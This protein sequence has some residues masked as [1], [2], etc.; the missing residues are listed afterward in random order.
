MRAW[1]QAYLAH[2]AAI[3]KQ[4]LARNVAGVIGGKEG[5]GLSDV[6]R[7]SRASQ[8]DLRDHLGKNVGVVHHPA[9]HRRVDQAGMNAVD[10]DAGWANLGGHV[11]REGFDGQLA[12]RIMRASGKDLSRLDGT[13]VHDGALA[14]LR[15]QPPAEDLRGHP[16]A[17]QVH[18]DHVLPLLVRQ[19]QERD[20]G[21]DAGVVDQDVDGTELLPRLCEQAFEIFAFGDIARDGERAAPKPTYVIG[22]LFRPRIELQVV[23]DDVRAFRGEGLR[24][25]A[26]DALPRSR[27]NGDPA[28]E[29]HLPH[30]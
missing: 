8:R 18:V 5:D 3:D 15:N 26:A 1:F 21:L 24:D 29:P 28:F 25:A 12:G 6:G 20:D 27:Y 7:R 13:D 30:P 9:G 16:A 22:D 2:P 19:L 10:A 14:A 17:L 23:D 11:A 4:R